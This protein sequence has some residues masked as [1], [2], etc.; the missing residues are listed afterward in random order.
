MMADLVRDDIGLRGV[1]GGAETLFEFAEEGGV[2]IDALVGGAIEGAHRRLRRAAA[3]PVLVGEEI[4]RGLLV[5]VDQFAPHLLRR[6]E[7]VARE[8]FAFGIAS[9][10]RAAAAE[11]VRASSREGVCRSGWISVGE[12]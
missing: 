1:A 4:E 8:T 12:V 3:R 11:I 9:D 10:V 6:T 2:E 7:D 5:A